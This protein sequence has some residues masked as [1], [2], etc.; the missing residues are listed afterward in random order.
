VDVVWALVRD[1]NRHAEWWPKVVEVH[2]EGLEEG[3]TYRQVTESPFGYQELDVVVDRLDELRE[4]RIRC[5]NTGTYV[6]LALTP[7]DAGTFI[8][9]RFGMDPTNTKM[10]IF[11]AVAGKRYFRN[12]LEQSLEAMK[13]V[14]CERAGV[15]P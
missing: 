1:V 9:A 12:W 4:L 14:A 5:V 6:D 8:D 11:D 2:C 3:C 7:A 15:A 13:Q 10:R